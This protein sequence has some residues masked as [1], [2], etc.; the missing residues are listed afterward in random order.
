MPATPC[1]EVDVEA[2]W[3]DYNGHMNDACYAETFSRSGDA[4]MASLGM[5]AQ[6][7]LEDHRT[8][9]TLAVV[10]RY[11]AECKL[12]DRIGV[13]LQILEHDAKRMRFW[14][15]AR[16]SADETLLATSEQVMMCVIRDK[17]R[18]RA[19]NFS[20]PVAAKLE[21][22]AAAHA[23][24]PTPL[25]AGQGLALRRQTPSSVTP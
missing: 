4:F 6:S 14:L 25:D 17:D 12:G 18:P 3:I 15:E 24:L 23:A 8:I 9:F 13:T 22:I 20:D 21:V 2:D 11:L 19:A 1:L 5:D 16:R 7:R 10:I